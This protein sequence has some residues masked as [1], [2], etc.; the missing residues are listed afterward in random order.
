MLDERVLSAPAPPLGLGEQR[1]HAL[2]TEAKCVDLSLGG[3]QPRLGE[4]GALLELL[5]LVLKLSF[6]TTHGE[7]LTRLRLSC[8]RRA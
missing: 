1:E 8:R 6:I 7:K 4:G 5:S 3:H 2:V